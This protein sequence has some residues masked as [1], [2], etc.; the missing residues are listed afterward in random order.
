MRFELGAFHD[1]HTMDASDALIRVSA[2]Q[3]HYL[4]NAENRRWSHRSFI[5]RK[6]DR[7]QGFNGGTASDLPWIGGEGPLLDDRKEGGPT[8]L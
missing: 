1:P 3:A 6:H 8:Q 7:A 4:H 2:G 5:A